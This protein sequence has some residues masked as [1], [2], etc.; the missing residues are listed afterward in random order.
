LGK[1]EMVFKKKIIFLSV[2]IM[3]TAAAR[4]QEV[5]VL[6]RIQLGTWHNHTG[7]A[8]EFAPRLPYLL[9]WE[10]VALGVTND[11]E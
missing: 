9:N 6:P 10:Q 2:A 4:G 1:L 5:V 7:T 11:L 3:C 8:L